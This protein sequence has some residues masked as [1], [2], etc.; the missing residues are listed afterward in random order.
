LGTEFVPVL[1]EETLVVGVNLAPSSSLEK[2]IH[3]IMRIEKNILAFDEIE[4]TVSKIGRPEAGGH[5]HPVNYALIQLRMKPRREWAGFESKHDLVAAMEEKLKGYPGIQLNFTQPIQ[6]LFDDLI[7]G[8]KSQ[9]ALKL[10]GTD[11]TVLESKATEIKQA[12]EGTP[13][14]VD[15]STEQSFGQPQLQIV[16]DRERCA[17]FGVDVASL[18]EIVELAIG[19][20]VIDQV[21]VDNKRFGLY[22]RY[23]EE[24]RND[25]SRIEQILITT[26]EGSRIP[27]CQVAHI[28]QK[29][30]PLQINRERNQRRWT[31]QANVRGR[32]IGTLVE[33]LKKKIVS[34]V[35]LPAGYYLEYGGQ[36]KNQ[37]RAMARLTLIVPIA[38][39]LIFA[40][41]YLTFHSIKN[42]ALVMLSIP[43]SLIGGIFGLYFTGEYL[44]VP[45]A[46]G[47]IALFGIAVQDSLVMVTCINQLRLRGVPVDKA[48]V[49]GAMLRVRPVL[50]T[51]IT[52]FLGLL[53]LFLSK[54]VGAEVQRPLAAVV[55]FGLISSTILTLL[56]KPLLYDWFESDAVKEIGKE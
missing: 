25:P 35:Q 8:V 9:L 15:L 27:L 32:D 18:L 16:A 2:N 48:V 33:E 10:Y 4:E 29:V 40:M 19:G 56:V 14:L 12:I 41:L 23:L 28:V 49:E 13:G 30:G 1:E 34:N 36:F 24:Y 7:S 46:I 39:L 21:Y 54:G 26:A 43:L 31:I 5:P 55:I 51:T 50:M 6:H 3:T 42:A 11:L 20:E 44:S 22:V 38:L 47:F 17:R 53:P 45:A 52:T 37:E